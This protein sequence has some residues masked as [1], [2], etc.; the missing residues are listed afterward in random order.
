MALAD[1]GTIFYYTHSE[2]LILISVP[3][4]PMP[5]ETQQVTVASLHVKKQE[6]R[7]ISALT[8]YDYPTALLQDEAGID[9][10]LVGDSV[11]TNVL[12]YRSEQQ[13]T[14]DDILHHTRAVRRGT[15]H[16]FLL[17]D[18]P[19][20]GYATVDDALHNAARLIQDGGADGV[21]L[22][23]GQ[24]TLPQIRALVGAGVATMGHL[25]YTP[26]SKTRE[27]FLYSQRRG[28]VPK[29]HGKGPKGARQLLDEALRLEDCG[30]FGLI[31]EQVVEEV[32]GAISERLQIPTV[33]IG[34][35]RLC[36]GQ[37]L[38]TND[39]SGLNAEKRLLSAA[40]ADLHSELSEVFKSYRRD[41]EQGRFPTAANVVTMD[42]ENLKKF[43][44]ALSSDDS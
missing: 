6:G 44:E 41:V 33:G 40:Y 23:G 1:P 39:L 42:A 17:S 24:R 21:K 27:H 25:G 2:T 7:K 19:F 10:L 13:V 14:V 37:V 20:M 31:L 5:P 9:I 36:D 3:F 8:C 28:T 12:G 22:E 18:L 35:G 38:I 29:F 34:A 15:R 32:A 26:Q 43:G 30:I 4:R 16:A 11:G